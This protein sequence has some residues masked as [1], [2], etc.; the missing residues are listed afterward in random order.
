M[1]TVHF[2]ANCVDIFKVFARQQ[3]ALEYYDHIILSE[4]ICTEGLKIYSF[5]TIE[6]GQRKFLVA[7]WSRFL[8]EY[9]ST[10][11]D[12]GH[13]YEIIREDTPCRI[14]FDLEYSIEENPTGN[15]DAL[16]SK[17]IDLVV[18]KL[19]ELIGVCISA[20][21]VFVLD[22]STVTKY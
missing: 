10:V 11:G 12:H 6:S 7:S 20:E 1:A 8:D 22:S 14:Y 13:F 2:T 17:W 15:G 18:W 5:E 3:Q 9:L 21:D 4:Q 19:H 16:T